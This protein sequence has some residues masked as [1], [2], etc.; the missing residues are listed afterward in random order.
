MCSYVLGPIYVQPSRLLEKEQKDPSKLIEV[1][2]RCTWTLSSPGISIGADR[3]CKYGRTK[4]ETFET[5]A[6]ASLIHCCKAWLSK[7]EVISTAD[8]LG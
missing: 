3:S 7:G 8:P 2:A 5:F 6:L 1:F 4:R